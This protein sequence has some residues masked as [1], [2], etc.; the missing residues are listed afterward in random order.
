[1]K[2]DFLKSKLDEYIEQCGFTDREV[3]LIIYKRRGFPVSEIATAMDYSEKTVSR[4][5][6]SAIE[7]IIKYE[8]GKAAS[9]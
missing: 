3:A 7:K 6:K 9:E 8:T 2:F 1:M 5:T 4:M